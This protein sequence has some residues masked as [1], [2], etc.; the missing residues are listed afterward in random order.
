MYPGQLW[1][2]KLTSVKNNAA[3]VHPGYGA[4][5]LTIELQVIIQ[6]DEL[7]HRLGGP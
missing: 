3:R 1:L 4:F 6:V 2:R 7:D 5:H